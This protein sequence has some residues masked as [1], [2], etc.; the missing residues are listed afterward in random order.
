MRA[1]GRSA[2]IA[3]LAS[4]A[5]AGTLIAQADVIR[6]RITSAT[7][8]APLEGATVIATPLSGGPARPAR[9]DGG[10]RYT[11]IVPGSEGDYFITVRA[12]GYVPRRFEIKRTAEQDILIADAR[13]TEASSTLDTVVTVGRRDRPVLRQPA[14]CGTGRRDRDWRPALARHGW[15]RPSR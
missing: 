3:A 13:L 10:G 15:V 11:I 9:T 4:L 7:T 6:G 12:I 8:N 1:T 2:A 14:G 5:S